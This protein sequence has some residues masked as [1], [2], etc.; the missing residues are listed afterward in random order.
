VRLFCRNAWASLGTL[1]R[2]EAMKSFVEAVL[3]LMPHLKPFLEAQR[4][5]EDQKR[6]A[7]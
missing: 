1:S 5:E 7:A 3:Q 4:Q 2:A 6:E